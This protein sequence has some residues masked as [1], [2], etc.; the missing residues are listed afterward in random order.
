MP[1]GLVRYSTRSPPSVGAAM[2]C[3]AVNSV[4]DRA[5]V[6]ARPRSFAARIPPRSGSRGNLAPARSEQD[7]RHGRL[8]SFLNL[9]RLGPTHRYP[10]LDAFGLEIL[11]K[12]CRVGTPRSFRPFEEVPYRTPPLDHRAG[13][14]ARTTEDEILAWQYVDDVKWWRHRGRACKLTPTQESVPTR[15]VAFLRRRRR[16]GRPDGA[17]RPQ[18]PGAV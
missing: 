14:R 2:A 6:T 18:A 15:G 5:I 4:R 11:L 17:S 16:Q 1:M 12:V 13:Q 3:S 8:P 7:K 9:G 10:D